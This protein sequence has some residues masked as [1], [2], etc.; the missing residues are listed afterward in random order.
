MTTNR[1]G[2]TRLFRLLTLAALSPLALLLGAG[3]ASAACSGNSGN[4]A[5]ITQ[6]SNNS[7]LEGSTITLNVHNSSKGNNF[8][9]S[10]VSGP[11]V[12]PSPASGTSTSFTLPMLGSASS[13]VLTVRLTA[14][15]CSGSPAVD[16]ED[17]V[18][19][20]IKLANAQPVAVAS[21]S[22]ASVNEG[23]SVSLL[24]TGSYDPEGDP[25]TYAWTQTAGPAVTILN[26]SGATASFAAP[27]VATTTTL[28]FQLKVTENTPSAKF[29]TA[30]VSVN[31]LNVNQPP[32]AS[33]VCP[34]EVDEG[35]AVTLDGSASSDPDGVSLTYAFSQLSGL[36][37]VALPA[38]PYGSSTGFTAPVL[39]QG[40]TGLV[41]FAL[42]VTDADNASATANCSVFINDVTAPVLSGGGDQTLEATSPAGAMAT[43]SVTSVDNVDGAGGAT[44]VPPSGSDFPLGATPV[45]C[46]QA[47]SSGNIGELGFTITVVDTTPPVIDVHAGVTEEA[48]SP[49][50]AIVNYTAPATSDLYDG[51]GTATCAPPSGSLFALGDSTVNCSATDSN[52]N[53]A[54]GTSFTVSVVDTTAPEIT[55]PA[56]I[57]VEAAGPLTTVALVDATATDA[58]GPVTITSDAP[59]QFPVG[60]TLVTWTA[61]DGA[62]NSSTTTSNVTV[63][64]TTPPVVDDSADQTLEATGPSG[65]FATFSAPAAHDLVDGDFASTCDHAPGVFPLG[66]TTVTC[67]ATDAAGN[68][69]SSSFDITVQDTTPPS[70]SAHGNELAEATGP[71]GAAV[72]YA[73]PTATDLV[74][75]SVAV[76]CTPA[77]G[78]TF[79]LGTTTVDC[80]AT[81]AAGNTASSSF[82]VTVQDT[83]PPAISAHADVTAF[84]TSSA[85]A[86]VSYTLPTASDLVDGSVAVTCLPASGS[87]FAVGTTTVNCSA[88][89]SHGNTGTSSFN[90]IVSYN[91]N[92]FFKPIDNL[93]VVNVTK[94]GQ[95][96]P[97]K[98]SLGGNM[99]LNIFAAGYPRSVQMVCNGAISDTVEETVTAGGSSLSYDA[100][101]GQYIYVWKSEKAWAGTCRQLQVK[102][103]DGTY[104]YANFSFTR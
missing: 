80:S 15:G 104:H 76:V 84:A 73:N 46:A 13:A 6:A 59:A 89:D 70:I 62:M 53:D 75:G 103:A 64:D 34:S 95:A 41:E 28:T 32:V 61:T 63:Q 42:T 12:T 30:S 51:A 20:I 77:S 81:D 54:E 69:G 66:T 78:S 4:K 87:T 26:A 85:G 60:T 57:T 2:R 7:A 45:A 19:N 79:A 43:F 55:A 29:S 91:F 83:T 31:V 23:A 3:Q 50:G 101:T 24:S 74:D 9:W 92:G 99:G 47:D 71:S 98:F 39:G 82:S 44:C 25:I 18:V 8:A 22:A 100:T 36:P 52:G 72:N 49:A 11:V 14:S 37:L 68:T 48:T 21:A 38:P 102:L 96:I 97:V 67:S 94:A 35:D 16:T 65:A 86:V 58:V 56:D 93:P 27:A 40:Q 17:F 90:V 1:F 5:D 88:T 33:L 10:Y